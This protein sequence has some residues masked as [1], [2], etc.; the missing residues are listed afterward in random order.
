MRAISSRLTGRAPRP[1]SSN[2]ASSFAAFIGSMKPISS[3]KIRR[4]PAFW[5]RMP[6]RSWRFVP[7]LD[8]ASNTGENPES[9]QQRLHAPDQLFAN[10]VHPDER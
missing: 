8:F 2:D 4:S 7:L 9:S 1:G 10:H 6:H 5:M 3:A